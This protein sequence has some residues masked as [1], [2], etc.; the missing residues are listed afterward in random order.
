[1]GIVNGECV[2]SMLLGLAAIGIALFLLVEFIGMVL[3]LL[4]VGIAIQTGGLFN[5]MLAATII[6]VCFMLKMRD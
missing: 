4:V 6:A 1:V 5:Y 2:M 3:L